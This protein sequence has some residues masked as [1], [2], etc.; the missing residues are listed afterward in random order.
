[1]VLLVDAAAAFHI[2][3]DDVQHDLRDKY[4]TSTGHIRHKTTPGLQQADQ[5]RALLLQRPHGLSYAW[6]LLY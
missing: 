5:L 1:M 2:A 3:L 4:S 6:K